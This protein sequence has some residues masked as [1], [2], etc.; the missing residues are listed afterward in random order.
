MLSMDTVVSLAEVCLLAGRALALAAR[1]D[2][3]VLNRSGSNSRTT[4]PRARY[5]RVV[6]V[7]VDAQGLRSLTVGEA[8]YIDCRQGRAE[9]FR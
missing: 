6:I 3:P 5:S 8:G 2:C 9:R 7:V 1:L 4:R